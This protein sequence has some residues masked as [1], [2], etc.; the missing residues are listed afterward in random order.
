MG[1]DYYKI[2][3]ISKSA[4]TEDIKKAYRQ[5]ALRYHPDKNKTA[6]AEEKFKEIAEAYEVLSDHK[7]RDIYDQFGEE[8][9]NAGAGGHGGG[10]ATYTFHGD[11]RATFAQFFGTA[12]PFQAFFD[13]GGAS[14]IFSNFF[15]ESDDSMGG[16]RN[17]GGGV[18]RPFGYGYEQDRMGDSQDKP[19]EF[20]IYVT[21]EDVMKGTT[22]KMRINRKVIQP[23]GSLRK[24]DKILTV[25]V[26]PGWKAG[27]RITYPK[28]GDQ[29]AGKIPADVV[30]I[31]RDKP[32]PLF[33]RDGSDI[34]YTAKMSLK[35]ALL[36]TQLQIPTLS[37][38]RVPLNLSN[39]VV[40]PT[41]IKR[42]RGYGLPYPKEPGKRGDIVVT[43]DIIFPDKLTGPERES[44]RALLPN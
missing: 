36:G 31:I 13:M 28:E 6:G 21:L 24:E 1:K 27:T 29:G 12:N 8:G 22:K 9:L 16:H 25:D 23:D 15:D 18:K 42:L 14:N 26:K 39:E 38:D 10:S 19:L 32:H 37:G 44:L 17:I 34:V 35:N 7:K 4:N 5:L 3:G 11:P 33:K 30:F 20:D 40:K 43:F 41:T 2:L